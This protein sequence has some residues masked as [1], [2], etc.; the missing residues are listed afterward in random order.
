VSKTT[1]GTREWAKRNVNCV[2]GCP[3]RCRYCYA[4]AQALRFKRIKDPEEWGTSYHSL[5]EAEVRKRQKH[6]DGLTMF[7]STHD[8]T[9]EFLPQCMQV[10]AH[11]VNAGNRLLIVSKP[12]IECIK[13]IC[14]RFYH[15]RNRITF[16]FT[17]GSRSDD[18]L[19]Y[20]EPGA[21]LFAERLECLKRAYDAGFATSVS[22][23]PMLDADDVVSLFAAVDLFVSE[24]IWI[25]KMNRVR[26]RCI[27]G[28]SEEA[29]ARIEAG[30]TDRRIWDLYH[31]L[32]NKPSVRWK[33]SFRE[34]LGDKVGE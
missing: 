11:I 32:G 28:T 22:I 4:R 10:I 17:S 33:D 26:Q 27:P 5:N 21:P 30:Q 24:T 25:G 15:V 29:M 20:W 9:P 3:H 13:A 8:I 31:A 2:R 23:E 18:V 34:V 12:H 6:I 14:N 7:P 16:R 19:R 1:T